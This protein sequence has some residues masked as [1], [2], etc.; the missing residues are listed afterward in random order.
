MPGNLVEYTA[1]FF[2]P[3]LQLHTTLAAMKSR[4]LDVG[5]T[6]SF[7]EGPQREEADYS[8]RGSHTLLIS[9][10]EDQIRFFGLDLTAEM[11]VVTEDF[12]QCWAG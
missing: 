6:L 10:L 2:W 4:L 8:L 9:L 1:Y 11:A 5:G 3:T 7:R 12:R